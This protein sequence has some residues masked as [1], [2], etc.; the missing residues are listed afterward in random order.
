MTVKELKEKLNDFNDNFIVMIPNADWHPY[1]LMPHN[2]PVTNVSRG[3]NEA[4]G[5]VFLDYYVE[6]DED[7]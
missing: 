7:E 2:V 1:S 3:V 6:D 4:D 5:C